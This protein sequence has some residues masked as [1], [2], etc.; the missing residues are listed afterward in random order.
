[1]EKAL[2]GNLVVNEK[3]ICGATYLL[4]SSATDVINNENKV[5]Q[6]KQIIEEHSIQL[7]SMI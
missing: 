5:E 3:T 4:C 7:T 2:N 1:V 6:L